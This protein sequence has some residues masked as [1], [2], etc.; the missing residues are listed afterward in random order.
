MDPQSDKSIRNT[1]KNIIQGVVKQYN[2]VHDLKNKNFYLVKKQPPGSSDKEEKRETLND[3]ISKIARKNYRE[4]Y[5]L[6][7]MLITE[8]KFLDVIRKTILDL[9]IPFGKLPTCSMM[10]VVTINID[11][12]KK[13]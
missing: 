1:Q 9:L 7:L 3:V 12:S 2:A 5:L 10:K 4:S 11:S 13:K 6:D 8:G